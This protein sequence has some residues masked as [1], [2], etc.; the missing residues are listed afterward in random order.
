MK[1]L[2]AFWNCGDTQIIE[3]AISR[4][5]LNRLEREVVDLILDNC[6]TQEEAAERMMLSTRSVQDYWRSAEHKLLAI[7]W[8]TAYGRELLGKKES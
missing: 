3:Y 4:A 6:Y 5:R 8:V 7:P 2:K 1:L